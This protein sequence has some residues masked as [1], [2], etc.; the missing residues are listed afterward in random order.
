MDSSNGRLQQPTKRLTETDAW[1]ALGERHAVLAATSLNQLFA[2][3]PRRFERMSLSA[4]GLVLD[5]SK[6]RL[7]GTTLSLLTALAAERGVDTARDAMFAGRPIN[8]TERRAVLHTALRQSAGVRHDANG[9]DVMPD[10]LAVRARMLD[11][12][13]AVR[14]GRW[15]GHAGDAITDV[16]NIGIGGS[17]LGPCMACEALAGRRRGRL[18]IHFVSNVDG[19]QLAAVLDRVEARRTL[20][21]VA[22]KTFTTLE[23]MTNAAS[24]RAWFLAHGGQAADIAKHFVAVSSNAARVR[25]FG[26][27]E[28]N[29]FGFWDWVGGRYSMWSSVGLPIALAIGAEGFRALLDGAARMDRH[30]V[31]APLAANM[32]VILASIGLWYRAFFGTASVCVV[33]YAQALARLPAYLQQLEM[34]SNGKSVSCDGR[35]VGVATCPVVWGEPGTN[36]Q[37]SFFQLLHQGSD[38]IP[39]DF[40]MPLEVGH[41]LPGHQRLLLANCI[42]QSKALMV[43]KSEAEVRAELS[44]AGLAGEALELLVPHR[45]FAGNRPSNTL[46]L[47]DLSPASLGA[48][49]A[50]Y[51]HK[52]FVQGVLWGVNSFDQ[53]GVELGKQ[54]AGRIA[55]ELDGGAVGPHDASTR[56]LL[57]LARSG[58]ARAS[59]R[60]A[61]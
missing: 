52:V 4:G 47:P 22:S 56:G 41:G 60:G 23:T 37:H 53:W 50:L 59:S 20:F 33:P 5:Y 24:A 31:E 9:V 51:E 38:P 26:I 44:T 16:V 21:V 61:S 12:A 2:D 55:A 49:I 13:E 35:Q 54:L 40:I 17:D 6:N 27:D 10:V 15:T 1:Q 57:D 30:F 8:N 19:E 46:V 25:E 7:D 29:M 42:A 45:V 28:A 34:E 14:D 11:F 43:G 32:P 18:T 3:D 58:L 48:L 39:V 36:A